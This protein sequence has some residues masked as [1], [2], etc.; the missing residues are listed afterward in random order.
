MNKIIE[1]KPVCVCHDCG[2]KWSNPAGV[3]QILCPNCQSK[4]ISRPPIKKGGPF[5]DPKQVH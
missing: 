5:T 2:H 1:F 3:I 4:N